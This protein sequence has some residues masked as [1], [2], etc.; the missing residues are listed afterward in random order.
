MFCLISRI[1]VSFINN[2]R[3]QLRD[4]PYLAFHSVTVVTVTAIKKYKDAF[5]FE[6]IT[7]THYFCLTRRT[8]LIRQINFS[9][10]IGPL[11]LIFNNLV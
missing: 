1:S 11:S 8:I 3:K 10:K 7:K 4:E 9:K 6:R 5:C 2:I